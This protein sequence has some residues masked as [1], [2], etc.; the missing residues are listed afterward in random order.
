MGTQAV[1]LFSPGAAD[2]GPK[3]AVCFL[4]LCL[5]GG[6]CV[7]QTTRL[8]PM[9]V[10]SF[11]AMALG[12]VYGEVADAHRGRDACPCGWEPSAASDI[13]AMQIALARMAEPRMIPDLRLVEPAGRA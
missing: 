13:E 1:L 11:A 6:N 9:S 3:L 8:P 2:H 5:L 4:T 12:S 10:L 7:L